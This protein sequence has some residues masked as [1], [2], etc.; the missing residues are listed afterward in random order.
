MVGCGEEAQKKAVQ[1]EAK[2]NPSPEEIAGAL[3]REIVAN[4]TNWQGKFALLT[5]LAVIANDLNI[6]NSEQYVDFKE[7]ATQ[8]AKFGMA[9]MKGMK[10]RQTSGL[11]KE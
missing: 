11:Q 5:D 1:K 6:S 7:A 2:D 3:A 8:L 4:P 9:H 10:V